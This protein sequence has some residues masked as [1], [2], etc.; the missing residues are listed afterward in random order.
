MANFVNGLT[1]RYA[2]PEVTEAALATAENSQTHDNG[3]DSQSELE[4]AQNE[5][6]HAYS[7]KLEDDDLGQFRLVPLGMGVYFNDPNGAFRYDLFATALYTRHISK[8]LFF[9]SSVRL[10]WLENVSKVTDTSNSKLPHVR[11]DVGD[12]KRDSRF[13]LNT[14]LLNKYLHLHPRVYAR[15]SF[16]YYEEMYGGFGGQVLYLP[17]EGNWAVDLAVDRLKQRDTK[18]DLGFREYATVTALAAYHYRI[19]KYGLTLTA[20]GGQFLAK[21]KGVR[22]EF[23]RRFRSGIRIGAWYTYTNGMDTTSPGSPSDP[24]YDKGIF[25]SIPL[26][27]MLTKDTRSTARFAISPWTRDVGAMVESPGDLYTIMEDPLLLDWPG[28]HL[29]TDFHR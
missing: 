13:K 22:F 9:D 19:K 29:L 5:D 16:G 11:T 21:D 28:H 1:V 15:G 25:V 8:G 7:L 18:G 6:G 12:Y 14:L 24:Y 10:S 2:D 17:K 20:R 23:Q 26:S 4:W 3:N 27:S